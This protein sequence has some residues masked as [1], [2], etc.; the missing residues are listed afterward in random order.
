M[1]LHMI[2]KIGV[3]MNLRELMIEYICFAF[4]EEE[5]MAQFQITDDELALL[6]DVDLLEI[7]DQ[8]LLSPVA[9]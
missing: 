6:T 1:P 5:L 4:S 8:T 7:Y 9:E 2:A 3:D